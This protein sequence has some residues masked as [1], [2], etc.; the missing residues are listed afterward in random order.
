MNQLI[1]KYANCIIRYMGSLIRGIGTP[2]LSFFVC[3]MRVDLDVFYI[4]AK[5]VVEFYLTLE[6][7]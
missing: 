6:E 7:S 4:Y 5:P 1:V 3:D 2:N